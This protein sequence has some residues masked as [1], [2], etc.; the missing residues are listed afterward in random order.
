VGQFTNKS[1]Y[2]Q[3]LVS[4]VLVAKN[5]PLD[6]AY[7]VDLALNNPN[8]PPYSASQ[9]TLVAL[10]SSN[11]LGLRATAQTLSYSS[12]LIGLLR[13]DGKDY[14]LANFAH[15]GYGLGAMAA[16]LPD[17]DALC[18][19]IATKCTVSIAVAAY[20]D[21]IGGQTAAQVY[22]NLTSIVD[23]LHAH[24]DTVIVS[25]QT[26]S[27]YSGWTT[28]VNTQK[29]NW[30]NLVRTNAAGADCIVNT[31]AVAGLSDPTDENF[32]WKDPNSPFEFDGHIKD[33][34]G[35]VLAQKEH[36]TC[37]F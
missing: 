3:G 17:I 25:T 29:A 32:F 19:T 13:A 37:T 34:A 4:D 23:H 9:K 8:R 1:A 35:S 28:A 24:G 14:Q 21:L 12:V 11:T 30:N 31:D 26:G 7:A 18:D 27:G 15:N 2:Y 6:T 20:V 10:G 33:L 16:L 5:M 36:D 22:T